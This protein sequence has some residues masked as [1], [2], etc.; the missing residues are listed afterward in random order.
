MLAVTEIYGYRSA[1]IMQR[2][3]WDSLHYNKIFEYLRTIDIYAGNTYFAIDLKVLLLY[4]AVVKINF[5]KYLKV[6]LLNK[7]HKLHKI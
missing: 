7:M 1:P 6:Y 4:W 3:F 2:R 5:G